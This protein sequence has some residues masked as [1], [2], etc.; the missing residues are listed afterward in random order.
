MTAG[1]GLGLGLPGNFARAGKL[2]GGPADV[3]PEIGGPCLMLSGSCSA[4]TNAQVARWERGATARCC[5]STRWSWPRERWTPGAAWEWAAARLDELPVLIAATAPPEQVR[6][7]QAKLGAARAAAIVE[8]T[9]AGIAT[10]ARGHGVRR[11]IVAGG[12]TSGAVAAALGVRRLAV[13]P[14]IAPGV[15]WCATIAEE[16]I[17]LA[18]KSGNFGGETFFADALGMAP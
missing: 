18:L 7:A 2:A 16:P 9:L 3:L 12:E 14:Q 13:G 17:A 15:P 6:A 4:A 5:A 11:F 8:E 1:S 10:R